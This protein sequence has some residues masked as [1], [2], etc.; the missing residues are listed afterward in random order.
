M[1]SQI[2]PKSYHNWAIIRELLSTSCICFLFRCFSGWE[3]N[4]CDRCQP[5]PG[6]A[7]GDCVD[8]PNTCE[9]NAGWTGHLCD[10]PECK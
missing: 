10:Q 2:T 5:L 4:A 6:C 8:H 1:L 7:N 9:C 3:G